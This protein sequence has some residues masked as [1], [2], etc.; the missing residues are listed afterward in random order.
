MTAKF[1]HRSLTA[2]LLILLIGCSP[3][4]PEEPIP[5][6]VINDTS[7][8]PELSETATNIPPTETPIPADPIEIN[9]DETTDGECALVR[10]NTESWGPM[11][12]AYNATS[13]PFFQF[14][15]NEDGFYFNV[16]LYTVYG[17]G[18]KGETGTF[19]T[20]CTTN[21]IC[22]YL[23]PDDKNPY[24]AISG[25]ISIETLAQVGR[26]TGKTSSL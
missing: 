19:N 25:E 6:T 24:L 11:Y 3:G 18:W 10:L 14:H 8:V 12:A 4:V 17:S 5:S 2:A 16:E 15:D 26:I 13:D 21:G 20:N 7:P 9:A 22:V 23:V 1:H